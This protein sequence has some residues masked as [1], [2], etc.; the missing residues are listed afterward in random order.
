MV[1]KW[2]PSKGYGF[3]R[4]PGS[5]T[6]LYVHTTDV[7]PKER[8]DLR[9]GEVVTFVIFTN[10]KTGRTKAVKVKGNGGGFI[11]NE[12]SGFTGVSKQH[13]KKTKYRGPPRPRYHLEPVSTRS[14]DTRAR[15]TPSRHYPYEYSQS[16]YAPSDRY[17]YPSY[18]HGENTSGNITVQ[19]EELPLWQ[20]FK[21]LSMSSYAPPP[22]QQPFSARS[23]PRVVSDDN[24]SSYPPSVADTSPA[25][26]RWSDIDQEVVR[27][28]ISSDQGF[29]F[30]GRESH[31]T[32]IQE[33]LSSGRSSGVANEITAGHPPATQQTSEV[34][35]GI[36]DFYPHLRYSTT[37]QDG[38]STFPTGVPIP[39]VSPSPRR[40]S[41][42]TSYEWSIRNPYE[43]PQ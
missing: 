25:L 26:L 19:P 32:L 14:I 17:G 15:H 29:N 38:N 30:Y 21:E 4:I 39:G 16:T 27:Q 28:R 22:P 5:Q 12:N 11:V 36:M 35:P 43:N 37:S 2:I 23:F 13:L 24:V 9:I 31:D 3:I 33:R 34:P 7:L 8:N 40:S 6:D 10:P 20:A 41:Q 18:E 1:C 42:R